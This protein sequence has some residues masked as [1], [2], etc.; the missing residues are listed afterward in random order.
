MDYNGIELKEF[1]SD[2][3]VVFQEPKT[4]LC[5]DDTDD[6][7]IVR[8]VVSYIP[9]RKD[10]PAIGLISSWRHCAEIPEEPKP[11][12]ATNRE[13]ARWLAQGN[14]EKKRLD[15][16]EKEGVVF[17][18]IEFT[19][20]FGDA[21]LPVDECYFVRKWDD[22]EWHEPTADYMGLEDLA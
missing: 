9:I 11:R 21:Y 22:S 19:Y 5:W 3:P 7:P 12:R 20:E 13:L 2:K 14:G 16:Y 6:K 4:M 18:S 1:T 17:V 10:W 8:E 15:E